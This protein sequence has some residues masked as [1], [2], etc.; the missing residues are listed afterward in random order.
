MTSEK[1]AKLLLQMIKLRLYSEGGKGGGL[2]HFSRKIKRSFHNLRKIKQAFHASR[3]KGE[4]FS[5]F[6][7]NG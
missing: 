5:F 7:C 1:S 3:K 6:V 2:H 4:R